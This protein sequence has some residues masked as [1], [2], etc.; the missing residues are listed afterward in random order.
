MHR[1]PRRTVTF[2]LFVSIA[3]TATAVAQVKTTAGLV[4]GSASTEGK[5]SIF[6]GIPFAAP[7]VGELRWKEPARLPVGGCSRRDRIRHPMRARP[8]VRRYH[9]CA[10]CGR[11]LSQPEHLDTGEPQGSTA[12]DGVDSWR[13]FQAGAG[14]DPGTTATLARKGVVLVTINYRLGV[15]RFFST[16]S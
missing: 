13:R 1:H 10:T 9:L 8:D 15:F 11:R 7:P 6:K 14:A 5:L 2:A 12:G 4:K 16:R 3:M